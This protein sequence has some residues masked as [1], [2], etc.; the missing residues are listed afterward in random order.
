MSLLQNSNAIETSAGGYNI[1][2]SLRFRKAGS[3]YLTRTPTTSSNN[4]FTYSVWLK[5]G[6]LGSDY[7]SLFATDAS[8]G[9]AFDI[10]TGSLGLY[11]GSSTRRALTTAVFRDPSAWYH[12]VYTRN[13]GQGG[14]TSV[15]T[16]YINNKEVL[17]YTGNGGTLL[18]TVAHE[19]GYG[20]STYYFDGYMAE[21]NLIDNQALTPSSFGDTNATTGVWQPKAYTG[22]Y[23]TNGFYLNFSDIATTSGS[24]AGLGK[25]F[26]GNANYWNTTNI[27]VTAGATYDAMKDSPTLTSETVGNYCVM[28]PISGQGVLVDG[29][30]K[31]TDNDSRAYGSIGV[32]SGKWYWEFTCLTAN[33]IFGISNNTSIQGTTLTGMLAYG[34]SG[35]LKYNGATSSAYGASYTNNDVIGVALD[36]DAGTLEFY[37]NNVSQGTAFT[38]ITGT[39]FPTTATG[40]AGS[41]VANFGQRPFAYT[42]PTGFLALNTF[43][44]PD[45]TILEGDKYMDATTYTGTGSTLT[46]TN[47]SAFKPD[48]VWFKDRSSTN[49]GHRLSNSISGAELSLY[50]NLTNAETA[51]TDPYVTAFNSNGF[52]VTTTNGVTYVGWQWQA[53]Q[54]SSSSN[55]NGSIT[56]TVSASTTAGFSVV[57][58]TGTGANA[59]VGHGLGVAPKM[60]IVKRRNVSDGWQVYHS[61]IGATKYLEL[62]TTASDG[63]PNP[64]LRWNNTAPTSSVFSLGTQSSVNASA[65]TYVAYC[66]AEIAGFSK[67]DTYTGNGNSN[68]VFVYTGFRPKFILVKR[69]NSTGDWYMWDTSRNTSNVVNSNLLANTFAGETT[70]TAID[71]VSNGFKIRNTTA[72][73]NTNTGLYIYAAF[74]ENPFKNSLAR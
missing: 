43:N 51:L 10:T 39:Y 15:H 61:S 69:S 33:T 18:S 58:Y 74:A 65:S 29:N 14:T 4:S 60:I 22:T 73:F 23:G 25:D 31:S 38:G 42:P 37:K 26:S 45:S 41:W 2:N 59:T 34:S 19:I 1:N 7:M 48:L 28:N 52:S 50:S 20:G 72:G 46:V 24:N 16:I 27:S 71:I 36:M 9:L 63:G 6:D 56:S 13:G 35:G 66:W 53:G 40:S 55:T 44:L 21:I 54:G 47:A 30:L 8:N 3:A 57:T 70:A 62:N 11:A 64:S 32:S 49:V 12:L 5:R 17:T 67:F 68:G